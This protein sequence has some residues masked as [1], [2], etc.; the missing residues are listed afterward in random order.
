MR[1]CP[2]GLV[3]QHRKPFLRLSEAGRGLG[4]RIV[5]YPEKGLCDH[6]GGGLGSVAFAF[7]SYIF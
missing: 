2:L 7:M 6:R 4:R 3:S 5:S 1:P